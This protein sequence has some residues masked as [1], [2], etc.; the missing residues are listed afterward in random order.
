VKI[1]IP[2]LAVLAL[3]FVTVLIFGAMLP[4][5]HTTSIAGSIDAPPAEVFAII[6]DV[7][8]APRWRHGVQSVQMLPPDDGRERWVETLGRDQKMTFTALRTIPPNADGH[9]LREVQLND[10]D[11]SYGGT[12]TYTI[13]PGPA[14]TITVLTITENGFIKP[15]LYRFMMAHVVGMKR[16]LD[17]YMR[18]LQAATQSQP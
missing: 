1:A 10:P 6:T 16:N 9:A 12:W 18:D 7:A 17:Q 5:E 8:A 3:A 14:P 11:A 13:V 4:R 2:V 15:W